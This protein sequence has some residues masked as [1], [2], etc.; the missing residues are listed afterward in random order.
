MSTKKKRLVTVLGALVATATI[1]CV[2]VI[3]DTGESGREGGGEG[4]GEEGGTR[5]PPDQM[6]IQERKGSLLI[7]GYVPDARAFVGVV[8]N[9]SDATLQQVRVEVHLF[10]R[11]NELGPT[12]PVDLAPGQIVDVSL[13]ATDQAF[14]G[15]TPHAEVGPG[16]GGEDGEHGP[17]GENGG[18]GGEHSSGGL[19]ER[20]ER[21]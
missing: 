4:A 19:R 9:I 3:A 6:F 5:I 8:G 7:L 20:D 2:A 16:S 21:R 18:E 12:T 10:N 11:N 1:A 17:G 13:P 14:D 15:W